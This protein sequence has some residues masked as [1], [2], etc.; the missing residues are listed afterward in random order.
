[1]SRFLSS[2]YSIKNLLLPMEYR[3]RWLTKEEDSEHARLPEWSLT[4]RSRVVARWFKHFYWRS[5]AKAATVDNIYPQLL[6]AKSSILRQT[7]SSMK[8]IGCL[9]KWPRHEQRERF[10]CKFNILSSLLSTTRR[11]LIANFRHI[12]TPKGRGQHISIILKP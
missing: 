4:T 9:W 7:V 8:W 6:K 11:L 5:R 12:S 3:G 10:L 1:M 2:N